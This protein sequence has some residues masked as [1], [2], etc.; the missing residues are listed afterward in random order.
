MIRRVH[1]EGLRD[2]IPVTRSHA[3]S[4]VST[5]L[6]SIHNLGATEGSVIDSQNSR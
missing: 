3:M 6:S 4:T 5:A 2:R 1:T